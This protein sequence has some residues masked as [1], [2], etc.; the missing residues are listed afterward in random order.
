MRRWST[1]WLPAVRYGLAV[2]GLAA[3]IVVAGLLAM[4]AQPGTAVSIIYPA[5]GLGLA[6]LW[7]FGLRWWPSVLVAHFL[8]SYRISESFWIAGL[9]AC[10]EL[11]V[12]L[13]LLEIVERA[14]VSRNLS[15][16]RDLG[17][18]ALWSLIVAAIGGGIVAF[19]EWMFAEG[20]PTK[21]FTDA[22]F[23][24]L[25]DFVSILV[26]VP[27]VVSWRRW[28]FVD[29]LQFRRW[30]AVSLALIALG[31]VIIFNAAASSIL[32][33]LLP[34]VVFASLLAGVAGASSSAVVLL[35]VLLGLQFSGPTAP[36][37]ALIRVLF[38][39]TAAGTGYFLAIIWGE[40]ERSARR[41]EHLARH[42]AL[43]GMYTRYEM[44]HRLRNML[45]GGDVA[46]HALLYLDLDQ[47][48]LVNDTCGHMAG[49]RMLQELSMELQKA[50]PEGA[51]FA[52][53]G[54]DEFGCI[55]PQTTEEAAL[56]V[57]RS[58]HQATERYRFSVGGMSF[59]VGVS[60]GITFFP[61]A[62]GD[63]A[64][65]ILGR[66]DIACFK[67][68]EDGRNR[69]H[70]Y[71]PGD[72]AMLKWHSAIHEVSQLEIAMES[73][74]FRLYRQAIVDIRHGAR[75][76]NFHEV[77]LRLDQEGEMRSAS[78]FL[79]LAQQFGMMERIDRWVLERTCE[80]LAGRKDPTLRLSFNVSGATLNEPSFYELV[81]AAPDRY[82]IR[83]AQ[84]CLEVT[85][86]VTIHRLRQAVTAM[87]RL[88]S[89]GFDIALDDF[90]A[91]IASFA[92]LHE[93]P[94][95]MVKLDGRFVRDLHTDPASEVII[96]TLV[97]LARLRRIIC[98]AE[99][100]DSQETI[101]RLRKLGVTYAQGFF[102]D[103]PRPLESTASGVAIS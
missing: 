7:S 65:S 15:R 28:P 48:K 40:R 80:F 97:R 77:L 66:A 38:V 5:T 10:V 42:D 53:L 4:L 13:L 43:T 59:G 1:G 94:V 89:R 102:L 8:L 37:D 32:F 93:L 23:F 69:S 39:A 26:F 14:N 3:G 52:R 70:V 33:L 96:D 90:G 45:G 72:E 74:R 18:F 22:T 24:W 67:A 75:D 54:G 56:E 91:G 88:R 73:G 34:F 35:A 84:L 81:S 76:S 36:S 71:L 68:K 99:W 19:G 101:D 83:P 25:S 44:D 31:V 64:D 21:I 6:L 16:L 30:G 49:D 9:V 20:A 11:L 78:E 17:L 86:G 103:V 63:T 51:L 41:L 79:P 98:I 46:R 62:H 50:A 61:S 27:L 85:E 60:I 12:C 2:S 82:G 100:V 47:F 55:I 29:P 87:E 95:T 92:Y 58:F 57:S